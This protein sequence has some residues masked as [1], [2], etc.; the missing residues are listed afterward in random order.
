MNPRS[1][2]E[3][4]EAADSSNFL[5]LLDSARQFG[6][7]EGGPQLDVDRCVWI[8]EQAKSRG[9]TPREIG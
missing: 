6:L 8:L 4:Q 2:K 1:P 3:W 9:I 5:L 7:I